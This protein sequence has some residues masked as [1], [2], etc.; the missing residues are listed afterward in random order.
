MIQS[1]M[2]EQLALIHDACISVRRHA[3]ALHY[4]SIES[5]ANEVQFCTSASLTDWRR[6]NNVLWL[7][8]HAIAC[9]EGAHHNMFTV[10]RNHGY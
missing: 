8:L 7:Q 1:P 5:I 2:C 6:V 9:S 4:Y 10:S 3:D